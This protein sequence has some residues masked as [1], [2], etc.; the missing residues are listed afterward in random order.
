M[1]RL[2]KLEK[3]IA[4]IRRA[5]EDEDPRLTNFQMATAFYSSH[6]DDIDQEISDAWHIEKLTLLFG[7]HRPKPKGQESE[8]LTLEFTL[9]FK[10]L[11]PKVELKPGVKVPREEAT[12]DSVR[13]LVARLETRQSPQLIQAKRWLEVME[14][15]EK[16]GPRVTWGDVLKWEA[17]AAKFEEQDTKA[18]RGK[19]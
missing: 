17:R 2:S 15:Y 16:R 6:R 7:K 5:A 9:G 3:L 11:P 18:R 14:K 1:P 4:A 19:A 8:Q 12:I 10:R 13:R